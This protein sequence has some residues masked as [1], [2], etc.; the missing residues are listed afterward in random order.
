[1]HTLPVCFHSFTVDVPSSSFSAV[2]IQQFEFGAIIISTL[3][4]LQDVEDSSVIDIS[5][6][7]SK[8]HT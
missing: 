1:M 2:L 3:A 5:K 7:V 8:V 6:A 4:H